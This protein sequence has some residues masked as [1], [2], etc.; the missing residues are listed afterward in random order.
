MPAE[1]RNALHL[2]AGD[3]LVWIFDGATLRVLRLPK[4]PVAAL[5][6]SG[7]G[8]RLTEKLLASRSAERPGRQM[9]HANL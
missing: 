4:N 9:N 5:R 2:S 1:I 8:Q 7:R 6:G 3:T